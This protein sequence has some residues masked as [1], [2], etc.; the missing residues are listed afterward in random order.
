[1]RVVAEN[2]EKPDGK[3]EEHIKYDQKDD[4]IFLSLMKG[5]ASFL[6][7]A[8]VV[9]G[10]LL[11]GAI[12][13]IGN[14][15]GDLFGGHKDEK[16]ARQNGDTATI[17]QKQSKPEP[18]RKVAP[19]VAPAARNVP[20]ATAVRP[21][22]VSLA[23][24]ELIDGSL[25]AM[26]KVS[27][28]REMAEVSGLRFKQRSGEYASANGG[29]LEVIT[30]DSIRQVSITMGNTTRYFRQIQVSDGLQ[31]ETGMVAT[32]WL[33]TDVKGGTLKDKDGK[34]S[35]RLAFQGY[36]GELGDGSA[37]TRSLEQVAKGRLNP[38]TIKAAEFAQHLFDENPIL[39]AEGGKEKVSG[40]IYGSHSMGAANALVA[41]AVTDLEG[42][43]STLSLFVEPA[44][45]SQQKK[46]V[47]DALH[48]PNSS[49]STALVTRFAPGAIYNEA[50]LLDKGV[51][52]SSITI[53]SI[54]R[55]EAGWAGTSVASL[56]VGE[57][58]RQAQSHEMGRLLARNLGKDIQPIFES[59][60]NNPNNAPIGI[61][62]YQD[63]TGTANISPNQSEMARIDPYHQLP[64]IMEGIARGNH[65][66]SVA[67][68]DG[69]SKAL[70]VVPPEASPLE[71]ASLT[72]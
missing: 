54:H 68:V 50:E 69:H 11:F 71:V 23:M 1:M 57:D 67:T 51:N 64:N 4:N 61:A 59:S 53:R 8:L 36:T 39:K 44:A 7:M 43:P 45:A 37:Q 49:L 16:Q 3:T 31:N 6:I 13:G 21:G 17:A 14:F 40:V 48:D 42:V 52:N 15:V 70:A 72:K 12:K 22:A 56:H 19:A 20:E 2:K 46:L 5:L 32:A 30:N 28:A 34:F 58:M 66:V 27:D 60:Q 41:R 65:I 26:S 9:I 55:D 24:E 63:M 47:Q 25:T 10:S 18:E 29:K 35:V 33:E 62:L 38:Q